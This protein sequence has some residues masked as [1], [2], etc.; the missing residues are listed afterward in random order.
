MTEKKLF[1]Y[2]IF[3]SYLTITITFQRCSN[4]NICPN[5][6]NNI[7]ERLLTDEPPQKVQKQ[8]KNNFSF[9]FK[10]KNV[11][12]KLDELKLKMNFTGIQQNES[13]KVSSD[14]QV[15]YTINFYDKE[16]LGVDD[17]RAVLKGIE[18]LYNY[19][20]V[21]KGDKTK[22]EINWEINIKEN[23]EKNQI[24]QLIAEASLNDIKEIY[25][26]NSFVFKY[27][28]EKEKEKKDKTFEFWLI[29]YGFTGIIVITFIGMFIYLIITNKVGKNNNNLS[30]I[31]VGF[32]ESI[33]SQ[34]QECK[35]G[36]LRTTA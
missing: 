20:L 17:I 34:D 21:K 23:E 29:F 14:F 24:V 1:S 6:I 27:T 26:Y 33:V 18:P 30:N 36:S 25:A 35:L 31:S 10:D 22:G 5:N 3:I 8:I 13:E 16:K 15:I 11:A 4:F 2:L 19:S 28:K 32:N 12:T 9:F 7:L